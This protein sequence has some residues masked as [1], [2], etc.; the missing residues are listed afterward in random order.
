MQGDSPAA[1]PASIAARRGRST[2]LSFDRHHALAAKSAIL[3]PPL[4]NPHP[5]Y[6]AA[7]PAVQ[8]I[9]A[10]N[11]IRMLDV[12]AEGSGGVSVNHSA[13]YLLNGFLDHILFNILLAAKSTKLIAVRPAVADVLK[14]R[15]A[16]EIVS[17]ADDE[18][19]EYM[20]GTDEE[21]LSNDRGGHDPSGHFELERSWKLTRLRCM[22]YAR[23]GDMEEEDEED[24]LQREGLH[25]NNGRPCR[26]SN[27]IGLITPAAAIFLTAI[28][29]YIAENALIL[30]GENASIRLGLSREANEEDEDGEM[31]NTLTQTLSVED[32]DME[33]I[34]LNPTLGRL[35]RTWRKNIRVP[36]LSRTLSRESLVRRGRFGTAKTSSRQSSIGTVETF[37]EAPFRRVSP[38]SPVSE[39]AEYFDPAEIPLPVTDTDIDEIEIPGFKAELRIAMPARSIRPRS[40]F[41]LGTDLNSLA[42]SRSNSPNMGGSPPP[43]SR[44]GAHLRSHSLPDTVR[45][46]HIRSSPRSHRTVSSTSSSQTSASGTLETMKEDEEVVEM[47]DAAA[48]SANNEICPRNN[49]RDSM[50]PAVSPAVSDHDETVSMVSSI[51]TS[52]VD[53]TGNSHELTNPISVSEG[54]NHFSRIC[55]EEDI[56]DSSPAFVS[57]PHLY[58]DNNVDSMPQ[59]N[60]VKKQPELD[61]QTLTASTD[62]IPDSK[63]STEPGATYH[64]AIV[65]TAFVAHS[66]KP[67]NQPRLTP[68]R[69]IVVASSEPP[70]IPQSHRPVAS[71]RVSISEGSETSLPPR[72]KPWNAKSTANGKLKHSAPSVSPGIDRAGVQRVAPPT[73]RD[74]SKPRRS[75]SFGSH[76]EKRSITGS[77]TSQVSNKLRGLVGRQASD[78]STHTRGSI[79]STRPQLR[80]EEPTAALEELLKSGE[81]IH[82]TLTPRNMR[83]MEDPDS[84]RWTSMRSD[85]IDPYNDKPIDDKQGLRIVTSGDIRQNSHLA[86]SSAV[87]SP[88]SQR[89]ESPVTRAPQV[90]SPTRPNGP[91]LQARDARADLSSVRDF[92]DFIRASEPAHTV[93]TASGNSRFARSLPNSPIAPAPSKVLYPRSAI[94]KQGGAAPKR[95]RMKM[96]AREAVAPHD[97]RTSDLIDFIREGPPSERH[98]IPRTVAPFRT[99]MDSDDFMSYTSTRNGHDTIGHASIISTQDGSMA[100]KSVNSSFNSRTALLESSNRSSNKNQ[101]GRIAPPSVSVAPPQRNDSLVP[102]AR[103]RRRVKDPYAIDSESED[104]FEEQPAVPKQKAKEEESIVDFLNS[105]TPPAPARPLPFTVNMAKVNSNP[106]IHSNHNTVA[107]TKPKT[108]MKSRMMRSASIDR[109]P[110]LKISRS[111]LRSS[112]SATNHMYMTTSSPPPIPSKSDFPARY[113]Q[114][115]TQPP[116][117]TKSYIIGDDLA[118]MHRQIPQKLMARDAADDLDRKAY[119]NKNNTAALADFFKNTVPPPS[120]PSR[121]ATS[122]HLSGMKDEN[123][124][125]WHFRKVFTR[126]KK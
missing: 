111:S 64:D 56:Y 21:E 22:V 19:N 13:L 101:N 93:L 54:N 24:H 3:S 14:P 105:V 78:N 65:E 11:G 6:V 84:P 58:S 57:S 33:K 125:N 110:T 122:P 121:Q 66:P 20:G 92:A 61:E 25:E 114:P 73:P 4:V 90:S 23:L 7:S 83:E 102:P 71:D 77:N 18:L 72:N 50:E 9:A 27:H 67:N 68:L 74:S 59:F 44:K 120:P 113:T 123:S 95:P 48:S 32:V 119:P 28:L 10:A 38:G 34:A 104:E 40:L 69:E 30:A 62:M 47:A 107:P 76:A 96:E 118:R 29:E 70:A 103:R 43:K 75:E 8:L 108:S 2:S 94:S 36:M 15:L 109:A 46:I 5:Q 86:P 99:T 79:D 17:A 117:E 100:S 80:I 112:K 37:D 16:K 31:T 91:L 63:Y 106:S 45:M 1:T 12:R 124:S 82:Y 89:V 87:S 52:T 60:S 116:V 49:R 81:T 85:A 126:K 41:L 26:F 53:E 42:S 97:D 98:R 39:C 115:A 51:H 35:W 55:T 88:R